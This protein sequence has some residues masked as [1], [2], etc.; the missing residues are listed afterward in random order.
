MKIVSKKIIKFIKCSFNG[1][2]SK[3]NQ[4]YSYYN[5]LK[6]NDKN[7]F[8]VKKS[9]LINFKVLYPFCIILC[10]TKENLKNV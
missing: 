2:S 5:N 3:S 7:F 10:D 9:R 1:N 8:L 6:F 4:N